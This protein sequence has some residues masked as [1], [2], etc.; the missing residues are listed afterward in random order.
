MKEEEIQK[1]IEAV[2]GLIKGWNS[3]YHYMNGK[4][5]RLRRNNGRSNSRYRSRT[6]HP[7]RNAKTVFERGKT[8]SVKVYEYE[9]F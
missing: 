2:R 1:Q 7:H 6:S 4:R 5:G 9:V 3:V 8:G